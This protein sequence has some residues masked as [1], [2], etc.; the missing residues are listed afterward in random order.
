MRF[1]TV[2]DSH[3]QE[4]SSQDTAIADTVRNVAR[5]NRKAAGLN[6]AL[7][8][9][10]PV[11]IIAA[12]LSAVPKGR[13]AVTSSFGAESALL[14]KYVVDVDATIPVLFLN[15]GWLFEETL[16]YRDA[17]VKQL[18]LTDV[19]ILKPD[20]A[21][22]SARDAERDLWFRNADACCALRKV[23]PLSEVL[24]QFDGWLNG[25]KRF[26]GHERAN[27]PVVETDGVRLKFNPL[28]RVSQNDMRKSFERFRLPRHPLERDGY[29]SI[30]C[31]PCTSRTGAG[32]SV[33]EGRWQGGP[34]TE[35]GIH[36][37]AE[38]IAD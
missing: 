16:A 31:M 10:A 23:E 20:T 1:P 17:L 26:H 28:A 19:R 36:W 25:R 8:S 35:C 27:I 38:K 18:K 4:N 7:H 5:L 6:E 11:Q 12:A 32:Q 13:L 3:D 14:L 37:S 33:R 24:L 22:L 9:A 29:A 34:K 15:T 21:A 2:S 30:G